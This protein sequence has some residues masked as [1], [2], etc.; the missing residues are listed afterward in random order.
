VMTPDEFFISLDAHLESSDFAIVTAAPELVA[1]AASRIETKRGTAGH[2][3]I[4]QVS[5]ILA[6]HVGR[7]GFQRALRGELVDA[8]RLDAN[9]VRRTDAE[10]HWKAPKE[11]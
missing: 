7:L 5:A 1:G 3:G 8:L 4:D 11:P 9:Y 10:L 6:P 2:Y